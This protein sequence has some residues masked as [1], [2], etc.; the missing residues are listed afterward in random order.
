MELINDEETN[1]KI[2]LLFN[3]PVD[4]PFAFS[5]VHIAKSTFGVHEFSPIKSLYILIIN[6]LY[7]CRAMILRFTFSNI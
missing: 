5:I 3:K 7:E 6:L 1:I 2:Q 4:Q